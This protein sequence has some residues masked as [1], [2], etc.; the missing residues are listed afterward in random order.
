MI[1]R[2]H[3]AKYV[4]WG[5]SKVGVIESFLVPIELFPQTI[6]KH[7][8]ELRTMRLL[9]AQLTVPLRLRSH[10]LLH[11][12]EAFIGITVADSTPSSSPASDSISLSE[13]CGACDD[14]LLS[15]ISAKVSASAR[16]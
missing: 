14:D 6:L 7:V 8:P 9:L 11:R 10:H 4:V 5:V 12:E 13:S 15:L 2:Y 3:L 1:N 16:V